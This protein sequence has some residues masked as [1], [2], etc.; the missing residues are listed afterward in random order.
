MNVSDQIRGIYEKRPYPF[1]DERALKPRPPRMPAEWIHAIGRA[2]GRSST[3]ERILVAGCGAGTEA[4]T[5]SRQFPQSEIVA[6]D[7]SPRSIAIAKRLQGGARRWRNI[8]FLTADLAHP[9]LHSTLGGQFDFISCHGVL[10]YISAQG[11]ALRN[12]SRCLASDGVLYLGVN[13]ASHVSEKLR[14]ALPAFGFDMTELADEPYLRDVLKVCDAALELEGAPRIGKQTSAY[15]AGDVF[16]AL[17]L[18]LPL[19]EWTRRCEEAGLHL[20]CARSSVRAFRRIADKGVHPLLMPR[21]RAEVCGLLELLSPT[22]FHG[23]LYSKQPEMNPPWE[24]DDE[25]LEWKPAL[26]GLYAM[27]FPR[28]GAVRDR[29]RAFKIKSTSL[30]TRTEWRM[31]EWEIEILRQ[32]DGK[33]SLRTV[34]DR[35]PLAVPAKDLRDQLYLLYQLGVINLL[36]AGMQPTK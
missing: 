4:F 27:T 19:A 5:M 30:N 24:Q 8:R 18:N 11:L 23:L 13:G 29:V 35:I 21:S 25:L 26:T 7:F 33:Q 3:P 28:T 34:L 9:Q 20:R 16:G 14:Q 1:E 10:S 31:P 15:L 12:F 17:I 36:P 2:D 32:S 6:V 22:P